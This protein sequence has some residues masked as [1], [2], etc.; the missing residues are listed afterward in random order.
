MVAAAREHAT[1]LEL[2]K[3]I[4][5]AQAE[6]LKHQ[7]ALKR[8]QKAQEVAERKAVREAAHIQHEKEAE[9][10]KAQKRKAAKEKASQQA[11]QQRM[12][13]SAPKS[14]TLSTIQTSLSGNLTASTSEL[15]KFKSVV[16]R[17]S[18][19]FIE[20][21]RVEWGRHS[22][23]AGIRWWNTLVLATNH[24]SSIRS[25]AGINIPTADDRFPLPMNKL[26]PTRY[27]D[28]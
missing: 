23:V 18:I 9:E 16:V 11:K 15:I 6:E 4:K 26:Q 14:N 3:R 27:Q 13:A 5:S 10:K 24:R 1:E 12:K 20:F 28:T 17:K 8:Q 22:V 19:K 25:R 2:E 7:H 21:G